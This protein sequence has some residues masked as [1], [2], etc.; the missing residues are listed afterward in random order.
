MFSL[1]DSNFY[2]LSFFMNT[3]PGVPA[4]APG[5]QT[6][7]RRS[8]EQVVVVPWAPP[9]LVQAQALVSSSSLNPS[10]TSERTLLEW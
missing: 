1:A 9:R 10:L 5:Q 7:T 8:P 6:P 4:Q 2:Y 3:G